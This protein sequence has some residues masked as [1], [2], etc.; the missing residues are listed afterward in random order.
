MG[1]GSGAAPKGWD[2]VLLKCKFAELT[3]CNG[4]YPPWRCK[5][6]GDRA[7][8][9][10]SKIIKDNKLCLFCLLHSSEE[11]SHS[12]TY[13]TKLVC[14]EPECKEQHIKWLHDVLKELPCL[15]GEKNAKLTWFKVKKGGKL[16]TR[17]RR[18]GEDRGGRGCKHSQKGRS[19]CGRARR[20]M[21]E[22]G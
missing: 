19:G 13:K 17:C 15:K 8:E 3:G 22:Q 20:G 2:R 12:K 4:S 7:P 11:I 1:A 9:E 16:M 21:D 18:S 14:P 5:A 10:R 6:F